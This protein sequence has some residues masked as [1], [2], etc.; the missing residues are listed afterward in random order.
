MLGYLASSMSTYSQKA[1]AAQR[2]A[3][4]AHQQTAT[5]TKQIGQLQT[6]LTFARDPGRTTVSS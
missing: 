4:D 6:D 1:M 5:M 2:D 3:D